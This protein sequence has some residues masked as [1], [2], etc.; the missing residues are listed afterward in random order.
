MQPNGTVTTLS[1]VW[2]GFTKNYSTR[3]GIPMSCAKDEIIIKQSEIIQN[4]AELNRHTLKLLAQYTSVEEY[5]HK[6]NK[7][8]EGNDVAI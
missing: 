2:T 7:I 4:M 1:K 3:R 6:L 8:L 5:E